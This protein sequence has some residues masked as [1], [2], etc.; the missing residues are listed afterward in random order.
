M[1]L[2]AWLKEAVWRWNVNRE[3]RQ[4]LKHASSHDIEELDA[5]V[6]FLS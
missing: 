2:F 5:F 3:Y 6:D 1:K 4:W